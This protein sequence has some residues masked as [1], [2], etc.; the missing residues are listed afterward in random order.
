MYFEDLSM[1]RRINCASAHQNGG[2]ASQRRLSR[3]VQ[4]VFCG[5]TC[6]LAVSLVNGIKINV[7][8][9]TLLCLCL[10]YVWTLH[11]W[12]NQNIEVVFHRTQRGWKW[13]SCVEIKQNKVHVKYGVWNNL[14]VVILQLHVNRLVQFASFCS[15]LPTFLIFF[16]GRLWIVLA[17]LREFSTYQRWSKLDA[18]LSP[19]EFSSPRIKIGIWINSA[20]LN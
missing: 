15:F 3:Q 12:I 2:F 14:S 6:K 10:N 8:S 20:G 17:C 18:L 11:L 1:R 9:I 13:K 16:T 19:I 4:F 7:H 5:F